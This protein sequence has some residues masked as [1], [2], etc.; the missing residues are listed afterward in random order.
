V[1]TFDRRLLDGLVHPLDLTV[2]PRIVR[3]GEPVLDVI[4][5]ADHVEAPG[6]V[7]VILQTALS[8][9]GSGPIDVSVVI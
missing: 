9:L 3:F 7:A 5:L 8:C 2:G 4:G 1:K 6:R